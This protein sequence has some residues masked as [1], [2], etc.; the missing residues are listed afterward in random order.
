MTQMEN[1]VFILLLISRQAKK[2]LSLPVQ[3]IYGFLRSTAE[4]YID[5]SLNGKRKD[6]KRSN[7]KENRRFPKPGKLLKL[8]IKVFFA[9]VLRSMVNNCDALKSPNLPQAAASVPTCGPC[10][11]NKYYSNL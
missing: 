8:L 9:F 10:L 1:L 7:H 4:R 11:G 3:S 2:L 5:Y 6:R